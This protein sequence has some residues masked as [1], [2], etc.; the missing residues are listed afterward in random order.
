MILHICVNLVH[1]IV[2][3]VS[4]IQIVLLVT[5]FMLTT[6]IWVFV[7]S[8]MLLGPILIIALGCV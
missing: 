3:N 2:Y 7:E 4:H 6:L 8:V 1:Q 5:L